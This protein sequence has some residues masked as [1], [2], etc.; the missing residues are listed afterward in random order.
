MHAILFHLLIIERSLGRNC[1]ALDTG[2]ADIPQVQTDHQG[3][4]GNIS[5]YQRCDAD[6]VQDL[7][8]YTCESN[9]IYETVYEWND[10]Y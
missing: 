3:N 9:D 5:K 7:K 4:Q 8:V 10:V 1:C 2:L 6:S